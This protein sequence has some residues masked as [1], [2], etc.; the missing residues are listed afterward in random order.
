MDEIKLI[1]EAITLGA[2][3]GGKDVAS[4]VVNEAYEGLKSIVGRRFKGDAAAEAALAD[5]ESNPQAS[6]EP[7]TKALTEHGLAK[8]EEILSLARTVVYGD[9]F[10]VGQA[11]GSVFGDHASVTHIYQAGTSTRLEL[12]YWVGRPASLGKGFYGRADDLEAVASAF[13]DRRAVVVSGGG[14]ALEN[15]SWRRSTPTQTTCKDSGPPERLQRIQ[16]LRAGVSIW[17]DS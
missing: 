17:P 2:A 1:V 7:L 14:Q 10:I 6:I 3:A 11:E 4:K 5:A 9:Q 16:T 15:R 8:D 12:T 13:K